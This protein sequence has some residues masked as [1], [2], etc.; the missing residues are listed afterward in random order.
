MS[1]AATIEV[2]RGHARR[3]DRLRNY[4]VLIDGTMR[5]TIRDDDTKRFD[6]ASGPHRVQ[7]KLDWTSSPKLR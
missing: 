4:K 1:N 3:R 2:T 6:V 7:L 5:G